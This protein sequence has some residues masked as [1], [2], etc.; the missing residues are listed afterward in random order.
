MKQIVPFTKKIEL[1]TNVEEITSIS[2]EH[3]LK[4]NDKNEI[5]GE[6]ELY[7]EYKENDISVNVE[8]Y[9]AK[10]PFYIDLDDK[11]ELK[12]AKIDIDD[13]YYEIDDTNVI[14]HIDVL[15][16]NLTLKAEEL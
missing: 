7:F 5:N 2:L 3:T 13:F 9:S 11:Y 4:Y 10:I 8:S 14:L 16:D 1:S 12:S 15:I 6:F